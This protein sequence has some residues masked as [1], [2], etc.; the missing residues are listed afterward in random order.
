M[1]S[2]APATVPDRVTSSATFWLRL[3]PD[4]TRSGAG[5]SISCCTAIITQSVGVPSTAKRRSS[6][7]RTRIGSDS[8]SARLAPD[9]SYS[10]AQIQ[11]SSLSA[12]AIFSRL[13]RPGALM[14]SSLVRRILTQRLRCG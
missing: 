10:G 9:C 7:F 12:R 5:P 2:I 3:T 1:P 4:R 6:S 8:V 14:P 13:T 11:M